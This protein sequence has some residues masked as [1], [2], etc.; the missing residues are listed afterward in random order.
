MG[1]KAEPQVYQQGRQQPFDKA[2]RLKQRPRVDLIGPERV[3]FQTA[4]TL[5]F[6]FLWA[7]K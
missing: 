4:P 6:A 2:A 3:R 7:G 5:L 1:C